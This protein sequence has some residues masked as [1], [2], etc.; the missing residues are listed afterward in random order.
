MAMTFPLEARRPAPP[1]SLAGLLSLLASLGALASSSARVRAQ[2]APAAAQQHAAT[3]AERP[4]EDD[5][6]LQLS[7][8]VNGAYGNARSVAVNLAG[9]FTLRLG[10]HA[11]LAEA[12][13][14]YGLAATRSDPAAGDHEFGEAR[15]NANQLTG[16]LRYDLFLTDDDAVFVVANARRDPFANL[17]PRIGVQAGYLRNL[18]NEE[19]HRLWVE[20]GYD[21]TFDRFT[22]DLV[23]G[24]DENGLPQISRDRQMHS[25]RLYVGYKNEL[26]DVLTYRTGL[27]ALMRFDRPEHWRFEWVNQFRSKM[28]D[29]LQLSVDV[30]G[31]LDALPPGQVEAWNERPNQ[32]TQMFD[33]ITTLNLVGSF[34]LHTPPSEEEDEE[35]EECNCPEPA[36]ATTAEVVPSDGGGSTEEGGEE[37]ARDDAALAADDT[38]AEDGAQNERA[39]EGTVAREPEETAAPRASDDASV[40]SE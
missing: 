8:G 2:D 23:V 32:P 25:L 27:E 36:P 16:R 3:V 9:N 15:Q 20:V 31:R 11:F 33:L 34:D 17:V 1:R 38:A 39:T 7:A 13:W 28:A 14:L 18:L 37:T 30:T 12:A 5:I 35:E 21:F 24:T 40:D 19:K 10:E 4:T 26:N 22:D 29:W 6:Q